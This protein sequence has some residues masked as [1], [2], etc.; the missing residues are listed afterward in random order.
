M[1][2]ISA[3]IPHHQKEISHH[4]LLS[5]FEE[6][7]DP[8]LEI[9]PCV[10]QSR[11]NAMNEGAKRASCDFLWFVHADTQLMLS[12]IAALKLALENRPDAFHYFDLSYASDGPKAVSLNAFG[13]NIRS[14]VFGVPWGDQAFC[15]S[16]E[17]FQNL[18]QYDEDV[19]YGED[20]LLVWRARQKNITLNRLP[21]AVVS[22]ARYYKDNG[23]FI[24]TVKRQYFWIKQAVPELLKLLKVKLK[25]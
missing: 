18:G 2:K 22:S 20:H 10:G 5:F 8:D 14:R 24:G 11:A 16:K 7:N 21:I 15:L 19:S 23:W 6:L 9:I 13:A 4:G 3:I 12:H 1:P 25:T 17:I